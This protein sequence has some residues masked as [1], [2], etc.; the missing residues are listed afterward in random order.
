MFVI[1]DRNVISH[2]SSSSDARYAIENWLRSHREGKHLVL[3][4]GVKKED[5]DYLSQECRQIGESAI[6]SRSQIAGVRSSLPV[7]LRLTVDVVSDDDLDGQIVAKRKISRYSDSAA[8][9]ASRLIC[10]HEDDC[11][12]L[13]NLAVA[14][15]H[16]SSQANIKLQIRNG[17]GSTTA[18]VYNIEARESEAPILA[19]V[20][21]DRRTSMDAIGD[22]AS[23]VMTAWNNMG[24]PS[25]KQV[26]I[27]D[28]LELENLIP[29]ELLI[30]AVREAKDVSQRVFDYKTRVENRTIV[31]K[32]FDM[33]EGTHPGKGLSRYSKC[34]L[35][36][37]AISR[38]S[39]ECTSSNYCMRD[40][41]IC[42]LDGISKSI[43]STVRSDLE[44][45]SPSKISEMVSW[46]NNKEL[47][48]VVD[49]VVAFG[50]SQSKKR[51]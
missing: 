29:I 23:H 9:Q 15:L 18:N 26:V 46:D 27:I 49:L 10:E 11:E 24:K 21:S 12:V 39:P 8:T 31:R 44:R 50:Y 51:A 41:C 7:V 33:K 3:L 19:V 34:D 17:G 14:R 5:L 36:Q 6:R 4:E 25:D 28:A 47:S 43:L 1:I 38:I 2:G 42:S 35:W 45:M 48:R 20:D 40:V 16:G 32:C 37:D 13:R 30:H 22:T